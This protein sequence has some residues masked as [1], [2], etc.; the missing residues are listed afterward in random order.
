[1]NTDNNN[2]RI[3][4]N[5]LLLYMRQL[6]V[7]SAELY[8]SRA[9][10]KIL[11]VT[12]FGIYN[13][14]AGVVVMF[15]FMMTTL[16]SASQRFL[17]FD[18]AK[19]DIKRL[20]E[21]FS[22][23]VLSSAILAL[24]TFFLIE[25]FSVWFLNTEMTIPEERLYAANWVLQFS[26]L[27]YSVRFLSFPYLSLIN[28]HEKMGAYAYISIADVFLKLMMVFLLTFTSNDK[29]VS[30][31]ILMFVDSLL[32][33]LLYRFYCHRNFAESHCVFFYERRRFMEICS[34]AWW[35][36]IGLVANL[37][38]N[39]GANAL[40]NV[41]FNP[42]INAARGIA[43]QV[44]GAITSFSGNFYAAVRPQIVKNY[45][46]GECERMQSLIMMSSRLAF[47]LLLLLSLP[48][49]LNV[50]QILGIW[51]DTPPDYTD[52]FVQ[53]VL[54]TAMFEVFSLPLG[55]GMQATGHIKNYQIVVSGIYLLNIPISY[56]F[57]RYGFPPETVMYVNL[58]LVIIDIMPRLYFCRKYYSLSISKFLY[59]V[60]LKTWTIALVCYIVGSFIVSLVNYNQTSFGLFLSISL[61]L[62]MVILV[63]SL[64]GV[65]REERTIILTYIK[66][67]RL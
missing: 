38:R 39:Q 47:Y 44:N 22:M 14:I 43:Y 36:M 34:F 18:L 50:D 8:I 48:V 65:S 57:L 20:K 42:A 46:V 33:T 31:S 66:N 9:V 15:S 58:V 61:L 35:N 19:G 64:V 30:Y 63:I 27:S 28:S 4:K 52:L 32:I 17:S 5:T 56:I 26:I 37:L 41:F 29:L 21:T 40:L 1:M 25:T 24:F 54:I 6:V 11:G 51:L 62:I 55:S 49:I 60:L 67:K 23:V 45:A 2:K 13:V 53:I 59:E 10:L 16:S 12:D 3:V 7:L